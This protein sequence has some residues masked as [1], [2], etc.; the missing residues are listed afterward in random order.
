MLV[1]YDAAGI[2]VRVSDF[3]LAKRVNPLT[4]LASA[5]GTRAFKPPEV[6]RDAQSDSRAGDVWAVGT[7]AY[8]L[9]TDRLPYPD[10]ADIA[11]LDGRPFDRPVV[12]ISRINLQADPLLDQIILRALALKPEDRYPTASEFL[13]ALDAWSPRAR[14]GA[15]HSAVSGGSDSSKSALGAHSPADEEAARHMAAQAVRLAREAGKIT[16]AA[17]LMEEACNRWPGLRDQYEYQ[18]RLWRRGIVM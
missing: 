18:L 1:G 3:G 13:A 7:T 14:A 4:L 8:L 2:R 10:L 12:P 9:L 15:A 16:E 5:K 6:F 11:S 17:D